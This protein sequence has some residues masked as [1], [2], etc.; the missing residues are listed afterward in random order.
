[1]LCG[2]TLRKLL[3]GETKNGTKHLHNHVD[4]CV[5]KIALT[6]GK[7]GQKNVFF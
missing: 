5:Q 1:M 6:R 3:G 2:N 7:W 4:I